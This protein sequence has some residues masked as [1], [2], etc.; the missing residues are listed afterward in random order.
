MDGDWVPLLSSQ[1]AEDVVLGRRH[2]MGLQDAAEN[3][4]ELSR[5]HEDVHVQLLCTVFEI[6]LGEMIFKRHA[7]NVCT[8]I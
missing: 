3:E 7:A 2:A 1:D 6:L 5:H 4:V 8:H